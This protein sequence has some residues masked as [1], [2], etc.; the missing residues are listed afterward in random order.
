[1]R[2]SPT[3]R[4]QAGGGDSRRGDGGECGEGGKGGRTRMV[5]FLFVVRR[6]GERGGKGHGRGVIG[7]Q[8]RGLRGRGERER[9]W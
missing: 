7:N 2:E 6:E 9:E 5:F 8:G 1:M 3:D 4:R